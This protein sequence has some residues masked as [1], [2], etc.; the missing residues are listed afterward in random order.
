MAQYGT[1]PK[2]GD[3]Y[4]VD[5]QGKP[6]KL[7]KKGNGRT[8]KTPPSNP[9][10]TSLGA[11]GI[12]QG[13]DAALSSGAPAT[14]EVVSVIGPSGAQSVP[15]VAPTIAGNFGAMGAGPQAGIVAGTVLTAQGVD[16]ALHGRSGN[17]L[18]RIQSGI[19][20]GGF[21]ELARPFGITGHKSTK[22]YQNQRT[23]DLMKMGYTADQMKL[24][25]GTET[26]HPGQKANWDTK[27]LSNPLNLMGSEG[28]L[29]YGPDYLN[30][31]SHQDRYMLTKYA[32]DKDYFRGDKGDQ[33][34]GADEL[35][36]IKANQ[37][38]ILK[39]PDYL[40]Q[41]N[42]RN[43]TFS[44]LD[45]SAPNPLST[46]PGKNLK[47]NSSATTPPSDESRIAPEGVDVSTGG[48]A[49]G[50]MSPFISQLMGMAQPSQ[51]PRNQLPEMPQEPTLKTPEDFTNAFLG[52]YERNSGNQV[53]NPLSRRF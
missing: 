11:A 52:I 19:S 51:A 16:D 28:M 10:T 34:L 50:K 53:F 20:T 17:P 5:A 38:S 8:Q 24:R 12:N 2:T 21:T 49:G 45:A 31:L 7:V 46:D 47:I 43:E 42:T 48:A 23:Q 30:K 35:A 4:E 13:I 1:D 29:K 14:P 3:V 33:V 22:D 15:T 40:T 27:D 36:D 44:P 6:I 25:T 9:L 37:E 18:A 41:F 26:T 39:N 32:I